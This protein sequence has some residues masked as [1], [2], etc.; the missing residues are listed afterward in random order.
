MEHAR[1]YYAGEASEESLKPAFVEAWRAIEVFEGRT[2]MSAFTAGLA[3]SLLYSGEAD[4][5]A[6]DVALSS[7]NAAHRKEWE[8]RRSD[9]TPL[10]GR[11]KE[12][13]WQLMLIMKK[14]A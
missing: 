4:K 10:F 8:G 13:A 3:A 2:Y 5:M 12:A 1:A 14:L 11:E 7:Q 6:R 9:F